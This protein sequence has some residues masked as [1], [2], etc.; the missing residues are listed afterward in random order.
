MI[1]SASQLHEHCTCVVMDFVASKNLLANCSTEFT[2]SV[3]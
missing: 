3:C 1:V 2:W